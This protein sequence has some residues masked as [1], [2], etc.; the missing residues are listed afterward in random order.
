MFTKLYG[1]DL[2]GGWNGLFREMDLMQRQLKAL[3]GAD[4]SWRPVP[5][6]G[7]FPLLNFS[8]NEES[9]F[10]RAEIPGVEPTDISISVTGKNLN[11]SGERKIPVENGASYHRRERKA[12]SFSRMLTLP[13]NVQPDKVEASFVNGV[14]TVAL[15]K[16]ESAKPRKIEVKS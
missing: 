7:V 15:P 6:A 12:G 1:A 13:G 14:L 16:E 5:A 4:A 2:W 10:V 11:L 9:Y 3:A 8:E